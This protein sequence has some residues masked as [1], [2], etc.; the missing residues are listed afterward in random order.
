MDE[1]LIFVNNTGPTISCADGFQSPLI[2]CGISNANNI[3]FVALPDLSVNAGVQ[4]GLGGGSPTGGVF[5]GPGVT[6]DGN[7]LT[8]T[9][10][11]AVAGVGIHTLTYTVGGDSATDQVEVLN[12]LP[13]NFS[14]SFSPN[15]IS[16]GSVS[17]LSFT[18]T[19]NIN[20]PLSDLNFIDNLPAGMVIANSPNVCLLYTSPSPRDQRGS[21]MP[22]SA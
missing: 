8:Y 2:V 22:S 16:L 15:Q 7:G 6:D 12:L 1:C 17:V 3:T 21:R 13:P 19:N 10:D 5:S 20:T 11:P 4:T 18:I 9:F 14:K